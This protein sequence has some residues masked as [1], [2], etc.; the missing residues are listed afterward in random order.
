M[1]C[2]IRP[3]AGY[4]EYK[5]CEQLQAEAM[6]MSALDVVPYAVLQSFAKAGGV[7][8]G[9]FEDAQMIGCVFGYV[10]LAEDGTLYHRSQRLAV[11]P[12]WQGRGV[13]EALKRAQ[14]AHALAHGLKLMCWTFDPLRARNAHLN[15]HKLGAT[16]RTYLPDAY[17]APTSPRDAGMPID[18]LWVEWWLDAPASGRPTSET[19]RALGERAPIVLRNVGGAPAGLDCSMHADWVVIQI[20]DDIDVVRKQDMALAQAWR[21]AT[22]QAFMAYFAR[23]YQVVDFIRGQG[24]MLSLVC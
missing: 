9:A 24:Y 5:A 23:G 10:G 15:L 8:L 12:A 4:A 2:E 11:L 21:D 7:V 14:A 22:R 6:G 16:S 3:V 13:G 20:P 19:E 17:A 1:S 18:R